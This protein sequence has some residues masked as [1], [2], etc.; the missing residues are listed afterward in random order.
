MNKGGSISKFTIVELI[1]NKHSEWLPLAVTSLSTHAMFLGFN[2]LK[3]HNPEIDWKKGEIKLMC[4]ED[5]IPDLI[6]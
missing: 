1:V 2:W 6:Q 4:G 3:M 5:H